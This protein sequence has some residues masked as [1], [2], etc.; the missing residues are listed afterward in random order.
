MRQLIKIYSSLFFLLGCSLT[1]AAQNSNKDS[2]FLKTAIHNIQ[3]VYYENIG[4]QAAKYNGSQYPGYTVSFA[5]GHPYF[6]VNALSKGS[7]LYDGVKFEEVA[8]LYDEVADCVVLQDSTHR[9]QLVNEKLKKFSILDDHFERIEIPEKLHN[10][11]V[12]IATGFYQILVAGKVNLYKKE[13]K[14]IIEKYSNNNELSI[15]FEVS[16]FYYIKKD[17]LFFEV[18]NKKSIYSILG[19]NAKELIQFA[20]KEHLNFSNEKNMML[21]SLVNHYNKIAQ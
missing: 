21:T 2:L 5:D 17:G 8:L 12:N 4:E 15:L 16:T 1:T 13:V 14:H 11:K 19:E 3:Q 9:I 18:P 6:K 10:N 20:K 7:I